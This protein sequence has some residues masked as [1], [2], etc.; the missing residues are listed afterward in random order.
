[1]CS[2]S[3][4]Y[5]E[6]SSQPLLLTLGAHLNSSVI[7]SKLRTGNSMKNPMGAFLELEPLL[8]HMFFISQEHSVCDQNIRSQATRYSS[9]VRETVW[10][11]FELNENMRNN[12]LR[13]LPR[14]NR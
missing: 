14:T 7:P 13:S 1:M 8:D 3:E 6:V 2:G 12:L 11:N 10:F 5:T 4:T 9:F